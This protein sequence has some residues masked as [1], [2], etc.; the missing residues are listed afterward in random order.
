[1]KI[2]KVIFFNYMFTQ[3]TMI[4]SYIRGIFIYIITDFLIKCKKK[5]HP[6]KNKV[7]TQ[8][9]ILQRKIK[10]LNWSICTCHN[11]CQRIFSY[12]PNNSKTSKVLVILRYLQYVDKT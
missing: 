7:F 2:F 3:P 9:K 5:L 10:K 6:L 8:A 1:M 4:L 12:S 11:C